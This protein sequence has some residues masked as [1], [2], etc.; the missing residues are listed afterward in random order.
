MLLLTIL[1]ALLYIVWN[2]GIPQPSMGYWL[3]SFNVD[4]PPVPGT[5]FTVAQIN[6]CEYTC[7]YSRRKLKISD[8]AS[9]Y[10]FLRLLF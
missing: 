3:K 5:S 4:P 10:H 1:L 8:S 9:K 2:N 7:I 6:N